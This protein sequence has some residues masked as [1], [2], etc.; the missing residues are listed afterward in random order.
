MIT[1]E[2]EF[3]LAEYIDTLRILTKDGVVGIVLTTDSMTSIVR[4]WLLDRNFAVAKNLLDDANTVLDHTSVVT[5]SLPQSFKHI[6]VFLLTNEQ[7]E[8]FT[9]MQRLGPVCDLTTA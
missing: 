1:D 2:Q 4:Q 7:F 5:E 6:H 3:A 8:S 9:L